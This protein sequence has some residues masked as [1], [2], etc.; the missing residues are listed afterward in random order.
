[1]LYVCQISSILILIVP[2]Q[3]EFPQGTTIETVEAFFAPHGRVQSV[4][5]RK[6]ADKAFKVLI[7][8]QNNPIIFTVCLKGSVFVEFATEEEVQAVLEAKLTLDGNPLTVLTKYVGTHVI[9]ISDL[10]IFCRQEFF[11]E[12]RES[13]KQRNEERKRK[14]NEVEEGEAGK[15]KEAEAKEEQKEETGVVIR[16][17][18]VGPESNRWDIQVR[19]LLLLLCCTADSCPL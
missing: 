4:R 3:K 1:M 6:K 17:E 5:L 13:R 10:Q 12:K 15:E 18:G 2:I 8:V 11:K 7:K 14:A 16:F 19:F 9:V